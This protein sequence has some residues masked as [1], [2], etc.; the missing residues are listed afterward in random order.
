MYDYGFAGDANYAQEIHHRLFETNVNG[1][2]KRHDIVAVNICRGREHGI[3]GYNVYREF[4]GLPRARR[5]EDFADTMN[6]DA[7]EKLSKIYR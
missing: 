2:V 5:F 3:A 6:F 7:I 1:K 4:C